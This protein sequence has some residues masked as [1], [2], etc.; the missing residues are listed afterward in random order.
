MAP[1]LCMPKQAI[2]LAKNQKF[3]FL[4]SSLYAFG[5]V[6]PMTRAGHFLQ[7]NPL[8]ARL[9]VVDRAFTRGLALDETFFGVAADKGPLKQEL[10][11]VCKAKLNLPKM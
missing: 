3:G 7:F 1:P 5:V 8:T 2:Q 9:I 11:L 10:R 6:L 4:F